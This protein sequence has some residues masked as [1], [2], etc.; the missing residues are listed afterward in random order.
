MCGTLPSISGRSG[1]DYVFQLIAGGQR[2][3]SEY[4]SFYD[5]IDG[6]IPLDAICLSGR[7]NATV[8][9]TQT[10]SIPSASAAHDTST[11][12]L[13]TGSLVGIILGTLAITLLLCIIALFLAFCMR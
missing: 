12:S 4:F 10:P 6:G 13:S 5:T 11:N 2:V 8:A 9:S 3:F 1:C 7:P